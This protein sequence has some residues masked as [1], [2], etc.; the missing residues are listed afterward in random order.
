MAKKRAKYKIGDK[1]Q[2]IDIRE[3]D[4]LSTIRYTILKVN[5]HSYVVANGYG[6]GIKIEFKYAHNP[7]FYTIEPNAAFKT[8]LNTLLKS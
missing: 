6:V 7:L 4:T 1:L 2:R 5:D 3:Y 8:D